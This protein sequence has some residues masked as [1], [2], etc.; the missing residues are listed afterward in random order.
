MRNLEELLASQVIDE[1]KLRKTVDLKTTIDSLRAENERLKR[2]CERAQDREEELGAELQERDE[3][4]DALEKEN[5]SVKTELQNALVSLDALFNDLKAA[6]MKIATL[7]VQETPSESQAKI[8]ASAVE[9]LSLTSPGGRLFGNSSERK[10][11]AL[12]TQNNKLKSELVCLRT[13]LREEA[14]KNRKLLE[15][16]E[17]RT[18]ATDCDT[19]SFSSGEEPDNGNGSSTRRAGTIPGLQSG[20]VPMRRSRPSLVVAEAPRTTPFS[21]RSIPFSSFSPRRMLSTPGVL[22]RIGSLRKIE[23]PLETEADQVDGDVRGPSRSISL[24]PG[25]PPLSENHKEVR[26]GLT[27]K[28]TW[29]Q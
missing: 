25:A 15:D 8:L 7:E 28:S 14:Y 16:S 9:K 13:Q 18:T 27:R 22:E 21:P 1:Q 19:C 11:Q 10:I 24:Q 23:V 6:K 2:E 29:F 5:A 20:G 12:E 3:A 4:L 26:Q 17:H